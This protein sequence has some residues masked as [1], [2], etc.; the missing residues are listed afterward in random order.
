MSV[1]T[2]AALF[3]INFNILPSFFLR[4]VKAPVKIKRVVRNS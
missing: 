3:E 2:A 1:I 4:Y